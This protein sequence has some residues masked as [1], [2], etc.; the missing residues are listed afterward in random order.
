[1]QA[2]SDRSDRALIIF[3]R[4]PE[5][6]KV[7]TRLAASIGD[8][9]A[10]RIYDRL[11]DHV[12]RVALQVQADRF[13]FYSE[14][15]ERADRFDDGSYRKYVQCEGDLGVRMQFGFSIPFKN[16]YERVVIIGSDVPDISPAYI[17]SAFEQLTA[18]DAVLGPSEDGGYWLLGLRKPRPELFSDM[19][20]STD[21][22]YGETLRRLTDAGLSVYKAPLLRDLDTIEDL[23]AVGWSQ[24]AE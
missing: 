7:K 23:Q 6:G 5:P 18:H 13:L 3:I 9:K 24:Y 19:P 20:W 21:S 11:L 1:M 22:V 15:V 12:D 10:L 17:E 16:A 2:R 8:E 4:N 14:F